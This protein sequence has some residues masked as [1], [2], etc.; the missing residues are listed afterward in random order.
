MYFFLSFLF[1]L[2]WPSSLLCQPP[3]YTYNT[4]LIKNEQQTN[5]KGFLLYKGFRGFL[6]IGS[7]DGASRYDGRNFKNYNIK[8]G[9]TQNYIA[10]IK[11]DDDWKLYIASPSGISIYTGEPNLPFTPLALPAEVLQITAI[12]PE[13]INKIWIADEISSTVWLFKN[14]KISYDLRIIRVN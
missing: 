9:L 1:F 5:S 12:L 14:N 6:W 10:D 4:T 3:F 7:N 8:D 11:E 13:H 2:Y